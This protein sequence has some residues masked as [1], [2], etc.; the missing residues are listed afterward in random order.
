MPVF[1][2][3]HPQTRP[4]GIGL[5]VNDTCQQLAVMGVTESNYKIFAKK[6]TK[7]TNQIEVDYLPSA[8]KKASDQF[9]TY[10]AI[11]ITIHYCTTFGNTI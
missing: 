8:K 7:Q 9:C 3:L 11:F 5:A 10:I 2:G 4:K 6:N 1:S